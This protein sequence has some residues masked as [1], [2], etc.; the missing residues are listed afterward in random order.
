MPPKIK[1][2]VQFLALLDDD[3]TIF[4]VKKPV[5]LTFSKK[6]LSYFSTTNPYLRK[7]M[8]FDFFGDR[9]QIITTISRGCTRTPHPLL[10]LQGCKI[11]GEGEGGA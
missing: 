8:K 2:V 5:F 4:K 11:L 3:L 6:F 10:P 7:K 1:I 9:G